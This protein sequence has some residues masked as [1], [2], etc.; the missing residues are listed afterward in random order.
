MN[1]F[2]RERVKGFLHTDGRRMVNGK[3]ETVV[4]RGWGAGNWA[5]PE[6][7]MIGIQQGF[8]GG[9]ELGKFALPGRFDRGRSM[10]AAIRE[11]CGSEY[12]EGFWSQWTRNHLGEGD[13]REMAEQ[14]YNSIR[15]PVTAWLFLPE[16]P[17]ICFR[18]DSFAMLD[19][20]L[21]WCEKYRIY[22][23]LD[24]HGAPGG[25]SALPCDD[26]ID[27]VP[28]LFLEPESRERAILLWEEFARRY[29]DRW[30][31]GG[32]DLL[33]EPLSGPGWEHLIPDLAAFY[34]EL[35]ARIRM[36]DKNHMLTLEGAGFSMDMDIFDR[37]YDP[38]CNN[39]CI[40]TH[41]Y[42]FSP[43]PRDLYRFLDSSL[44]WNVPVWIGEGG[45]DPVSNS[46]YYEMA[47]KLDIG[48]ALWSWKSAADREGRGNGAVL[49]PLP[50]G[51]EAIV[52]YAVK[53]GP[54]PSYQEA[55]RILDTML[56]NI[57]FE[58]CQVQKE[59][60]RYNLRQ[61]GITLPAAG[62]DYDPVPGAVSKGEWNYG[63]VFGFRTEERIKLV[64][65]PGAKP[66]KKAIIPKPG[67]PD[68]RPDPLKDLWV[69]LAEGEYVSYTIRE[70][71]EGCKATV[72]IRG[73]AETG[74][75]IQ[76]SVRKPEDGTAEGTPFAE[77]T[78]IEE[79]VLFSE[80]TCERQLMNLPAGEAWE[81]R[82]FV[83]KG[84][85]QIEK[86]AF[87]FLSAKN[88]HSSEMS[89]KK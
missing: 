70:V 49:Y 71:T 78:P 45:S 84:C 73:R 23:I 59:R 63:N 56:E 30:I 41:Y 44:R 66:P 10:D 15:L 88:R 54:R 81:V 43:E 12:A 50:E 18:E 11:L 47:A 17:E 62:F 67:R 7:F 39:W 36:I 64:L 21:D 31:V 22:A 35:I 4:L 65:R 42:G 16:E 89:D 27:T 6:G 25:Q 2:S 28:H 48:Y 68:N 79:E 85:V 5:N 61:P 33:N 14:G 52:E 40:H 72:W 87:S 13:I 57:C 82:I 34:E 51:W 3:G 32:Y 76:V 29:R 9:M 77:N 20:V 46:I 80:E 83:T 86:I 24:L 74:S 1:K 38:Q 60:A 19:Q 75:Q 37:P 69:E 55:Q 53:G 58:H 26:G 8:G